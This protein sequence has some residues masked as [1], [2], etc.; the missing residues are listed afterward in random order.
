[1]PLTTF[2]QPGDV[3]YGIRSIGSG[4]HENFS[5]AAEDIGYITETAGGLLTSA[6]VLALNGTPVSLLTG[7]PDKIIIPRLLLL[8]LSGAT[9]NY[10]TNV[11]VLIGPLSTVDDT[12]Y[13]MIGSLPQ[14]GVSS[15]AYPGFLQDGQITAVAEGEDLAITVKT[16]NPAV[17]DGDVA[18]KLLY[19]LVD[20][21]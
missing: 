5:I 2:I 4:L 13:T 3:M 1:M 11:N 21:I 9:A 6:Q 10:T 12:H 20:P 14:M 16:G 19:E 17:G 15:V 8:S 7:V 18:W